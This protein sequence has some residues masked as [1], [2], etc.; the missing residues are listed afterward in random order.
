ME[1]FKSGIPYQ[2]KWL[3]RSSDYRGVHL[4][5]K[6]KEWS[7]GEFLGASDNIS[8]RYLISFIMIRNLY[9][10]R[11]W[12]ILLTYLNFSQSF[13]LLVPYYLGKRENR[14]LKESWAKINL[15]FL[16]LSFKIYMFFFSF[17]TL[18]LPLTLVGHR[19]WG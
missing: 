1:S 11:Q 18:E 10:E 9:L 16:L 2:F 3:V 19:F 15:C 7:L 14:T 5:R 8:G 6:R 13:L 17:F 12:W 4:F